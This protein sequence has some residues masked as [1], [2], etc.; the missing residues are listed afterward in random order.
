MKRYQD[1]NKVNQKTQLILQ[2]HKNIMNCTNGCREGYREEPDG[3]MV[4]CACVEKEFG[5]LEWMG[6]IEVSVVDNN[7]NK[8][9]KEKNEH[10]HKSLIDVLCVECGK[11]FKTIIK[12]RVRCEECFKKYSSDFREIGIYLKKGK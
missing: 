2:A 5:S 11:Y 9:L 10:T 6:D 8:W 12:G 3:S 4:I 1:E 7:Y